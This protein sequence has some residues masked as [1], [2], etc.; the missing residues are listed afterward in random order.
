MAGAGAAY[1]IDKGYV[2]FP[3]KGSVD[4]HGKL[5]VENVGVSPDI[6]ITNPPEDLMS[7]KDTQLERA[8]EEILKK[9]DLKK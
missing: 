6:E 7:G 2:I 1:L 3:V 8:I 4:K 9:L 5:L